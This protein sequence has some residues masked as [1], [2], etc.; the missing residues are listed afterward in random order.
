[1][2]P[3][4]LLDDMER[5]ETESALAEMALEVGHMFESVPSDPA[6]DETV[7][8]RF[9]TTSI[10]IGAVVTKMSRDDKVVA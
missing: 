5:F 3:I 2:D 10:D 6:T 7:F 4:E 1:M 8:T 9:G